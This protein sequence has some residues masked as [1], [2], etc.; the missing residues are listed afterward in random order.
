MS[1]TT[2]KYGLPYPLDTDEIR[3]LPEI[4]TT[5]AQRIETLLS[6]FDFN[7]Q[8][9][10]G[11]TARVTATE[12]ALSTAGTRITEL[13]VAVGKLQTTAEDL[14]KI[15]DTLGTVRTGALTPDTG[16]NV[17]CNHLLRI[18]PMV[19]ASAIYTYK[20][21]F[22]G[23]KTPFR[24]PSGFTASTKTRVS[25]AHSTIAP[26]VNDSAVEG[27]NLTQW[28][29]ADSTAPYSLTGVWLTLDN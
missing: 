9:T 25:V 20:T 23:M 15:I 17:S 19:I 27:S 5:Q 28:N 16:I 7:G 26:G 6:G 24:L 11:L 13:A 21:S 3:Q 22:T 1:A 10:D 8:D 29:I 4:L 18:G 12:T 14:T 2:P